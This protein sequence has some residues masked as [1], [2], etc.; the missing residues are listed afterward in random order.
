LMRRGVSRVTAS[1]AGS[2]KCPCSQTTETI[3]AAT[4]TLGQRGARPHP[5]TLAESGRPG[6]RTV[7]D[8]AEPGAPSL[9]SGD[10]YVATNGLRSGGFANDQLALEDDAFSGPCRWRSIA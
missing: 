5:G 6:R 7:S 9:A 8:R 3:L 4:C 2:A 10:Q 1:A